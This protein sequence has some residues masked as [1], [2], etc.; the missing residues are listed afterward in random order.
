MMRRPTQFAR[1]F[2]PG[3]LLGIAMIPPA[4]W[5]AA[6]D[7]SPGIDGIDQSVPN[8]PLSGNP[9]G[10]GGAGSA[11]TAGSEAGGAGGSGGRGGFVVTFNGA[12]PGGS[13]GAGGI[14]GQGGPAASVS[15]TITNSTPVSGG[16]GGSGGA[17]GKGGD[18][19]AFTTGNGFA[20]PGGDGGVG[21]TG[22]SGIAASGGT[23]TNSGTISG[24][25]GG[26]G[27]AAGAGGNAGVGGT[28][29]TTAR[30]G[31]GG[32]GGNGGNGG[33]GISGANL[34]VVNS[35]TI[36]GG[37]RRWRRWCRWGSAVAVG[38]PALAPVAT[39]AQAGRAAWVARLDL[40]VITAAPSGG[41]GFAGAGAAIT[42]T[43]GIN[44]LEIQ[45]GSTII[46]NVT[47]FSAADTLRLG[48]AVNASFDTG[49]I[50]PAAQ[51]QNFGLFEKTG[52]GTWTL[53][54][55]PGQATPW[56]ITQ[57]TLA[58]ANVAS[59]GGASLTFNGGMLQATGTLSLTTRSRSAPA[60]ARSI[61]TATTCRLGRA[62]RRGRAHQER[63]GNCDCGG[64]HLWRR[65]DVNAGTLVLERS[66]ARCRWV[67]R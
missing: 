26:T 49:L 29:P 27:G 45:S 38:V 16:T 21:S 34:T 11:G 54:G 17:G 62:L 57:G 43:G 44:V 24:G 6:P 32:T 41:P 64:R 8:G 4:T 48:G 15:G 58:V 30:G 9:G 2:V 19:T 42:F 60:A 28:M 5:A 39:V 36:S 22:G 12:A 40:T 66:A 33:A 55:T 67:V 25:T 59:L 1:V 51:F 31:R 52:S 3:L 65:H 47:A 56:T 46:G 35:G 53:T 18:A 63:R 14:G 13:G 61:P 50:G 37:R 20:A 10:V 23:I 7:G